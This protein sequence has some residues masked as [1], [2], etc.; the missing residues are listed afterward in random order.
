MLDD[1]TRDQ[2]RAIRR[3]DLPAKAR[4]RIEM[5]ILSDAGWPAPRIARHL[6]RHPQTVRDLLRSFNAR[7]AAALRPFPSGPDPDAERADRVEAALREL[8]AKRRTWTSRQLAEALAGRGVGLGSRQV[9]RHLRR[10]GARY[11]RTG[12]TLRHEQ[13]PE[14]AERAGGVLANLK[15]RAAAGR[16]KLYYLD[17]CGFAPTLPTACSWALPGD[18]K[19]VEYEAPQGRRVNA[20]AAYR[21]YGPAPRLVAFTA[22]RTWDAHDLLGFL[23]A[24]PPAKV[25]RVVV[26]DNAGLHTGRVVRSAR[27][28]LTRRVIH[29]YYLP[30]YSPELNEVEPVSRQVKYQEMPRCSYTSRLGPREA[31]EAAFDGYGRSLPRKSPGRLR[32]AA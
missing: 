26:L 3:T 8:L 30:P 9:R 20:I 6:G 12:S 4:D 11:R 13:D 27:A 21:P 22:E 29:L 32:P 31:V 23:G 24:L 5:V 19:L 1:D 15:A 16:L 18:G 28:G 17:E 14:K 25:P 2:L 7:G 10:M